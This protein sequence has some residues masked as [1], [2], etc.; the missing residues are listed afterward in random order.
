MVTIEEIDRKL[1]ELREQY[2]YS[3][4]QGREILKRRARALIIAKE[5]LQ[6]NDRP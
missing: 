2:K 1:A 3:L 6:K 4:Y 5:R